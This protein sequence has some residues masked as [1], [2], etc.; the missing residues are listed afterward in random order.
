MN[1]PLATVDGIIMMLG[2]NDQNCIHLKRSSRWYCSLIQ[3]L[4]DIKFFF[5]NEINKSHTVQPFPWFHG[6]NHLS[7]L[8]SLDVYYF[9][10]CTKTFK[11]LSI[12]GVHCAFNTLPLVNI[13]IFDA[14]NSTSHGL[15][16][17]DQTLD[18]KMRSMI[19]LIVKIRLIVVS[20]FPC[21][22]RVFI[23]NFTISNLAD[24][25]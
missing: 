1:K 22:F 11:N 7:L 10:V 19:P 16:V 2:T 23:N 13:Y 20:C 24:I 9:S 18:W 3:F 8:Q 12:L 25:N 14:Q 15:R 4:T 21:Y 5:Q 17:S 6:L